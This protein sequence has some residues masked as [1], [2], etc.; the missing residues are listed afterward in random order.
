[1]TTKTFNCP[2]CN[3]A[4]EAKADYLARGLK[5]PHCNTG[6]IPGEIKLQ[7]EIVIG[8]PVKI[9][10]LTLGVGVAI[11]ILSAFR[12][13]IVGMIAGGFLAVVGAILM[14]KK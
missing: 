8:K 4:V 13:S 1:M 12:M 3:Q 14:L 6:F 2:S 7:R 11:L 10:P 5:C 9:T